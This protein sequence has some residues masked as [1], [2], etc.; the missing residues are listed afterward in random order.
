MKSGNSVI[1]VDLPDQQIKPGAK[2]Q[3][4]IQWVATS[5]EES[6]GTIISGAAVGGEVGVTGKLPTQTSPHLCLSQPH[7]EKVQSLPALGRMPFGSLRPEDLPQISF[8]GTP[9]LP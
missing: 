8:G 1:T 4:I 5:T 2:A 6:D 3:E 9:T 7:L